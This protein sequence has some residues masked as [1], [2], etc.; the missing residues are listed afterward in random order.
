MLVPALPEVLMFV[1]PRTLVVEL[2]L[3]TDRVPLYEPVPR[4]M[5]ALPEV[6]TLV[7]P[8][9]VRVLPDRIVTFWFKAIPAVAFVVPILRVVVPLGVSSKAVSTA[10]EK[11]PVPETLTLPV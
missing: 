8:V 1:T 2:A 10:V 5:A 3:P 4:L 11:M 9:T 6:L 7:A